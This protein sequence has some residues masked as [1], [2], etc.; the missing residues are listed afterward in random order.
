M[1]GPVNFIPNGASGLFSQRHFYRK[2]GFRAPKKGEWYLSGAI[3]EAYQ[4]PNDLTAEY[5]IVEKGPRAVRRTI[6]VPE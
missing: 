5:Q 4:A 1:L 3:V 2:A 6:E